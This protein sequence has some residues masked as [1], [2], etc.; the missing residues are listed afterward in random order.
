LLPGE[1]TPFGRELKEEFW[2]WN[3][4]IAMILNDKISMIF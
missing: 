3:E 4:N 2:L 1:C